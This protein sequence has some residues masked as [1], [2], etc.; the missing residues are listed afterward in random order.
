MM[1][2]ETGGQFSPEQ[3]RWLADL[4]Q[5]IGDVPPEVDPDDEDLLLPNQALPEHL[6]GVPINHEKKTDDTV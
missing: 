6:K 1:A 2:E 4:R 5:G 3:E